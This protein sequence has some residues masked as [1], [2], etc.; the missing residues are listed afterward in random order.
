V[1][2][3]RVEGAGPFH[4]PAWR[5]ALVEAHPQ[6]VDRTLWIADGAAIRA[7]LPVMVRRRFG[8][9]RAASQPYG[10]PGG[11]WL[12][13]PADLEATAA[14]IAEFARRFARPWNDCLVHDHGPAA[15]A[16]LYE[17]HWTAAKLG[18]GE[19]HRIDLPGTV[20][21]LEGLWAHR[22]R[23][24]VRRAESLGIVVEECSN[25]AGLAE[26][27]AYHARE[28]AERGATTRYP[29][30]LLRS[31]V[32]DGWLRLHRAVREGRTL[33]VT[34]VAEAYNTWFAWLVAHAPEAREAPTGELLFG[35]LLRAAVERGARVADLGS[36]GG[37]PG[38]RFFK[39]GFGA[40]PRT[41]RIWRSGPLARADQA[42]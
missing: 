20:T 9:A 42:R 5:R 34:A 4:T 29:A 16:Q 13:D 33:S 38:P 7:A 15:M 17:R 26:F 12:R 28:R 25:E 11:V 24:A 2:L 30:E 37:R 35:S 40:T 21:E 36:S 39:E 23:K 10:T 41:F 6:L 1:F 3:T 19:T 22:T 27:D 31:G 18:S 32:R 8:L 14:L